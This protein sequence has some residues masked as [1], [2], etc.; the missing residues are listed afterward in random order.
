[1]PQSPTNRLACMPFRGVCVTCGGGDDEGTLRTC[2]GC[3]CD[4]HCNGHCHCGQQSPVPSRVTG[5]AWRARLPHCEY[6]RRSNKEQRRRDHWRAGRVRA[7]ALRGQRQ[8]QPRSGE[9]VR[10]RDAARWLL[11][12]PPDGGGR[13]G[14]EAEAAGGGWRLR[15]ISR[16]RPPWCTPA[17]E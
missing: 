7:E 4:Y 3:D 1:M 11:L 5:S 17:A 8:E 2:D 13:R 15:R 10:H 14:D 16:W 6:T 9:G 12:E